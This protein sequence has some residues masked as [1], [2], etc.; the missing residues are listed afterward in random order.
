[1]N[2]ID[3]SKSEALRKD[4]AKDFTETVRTVIKNAYT[5]PLISDHWHVLREIINELNITQ[6]FKWIANSLTPLSDAIQL[7]GV[8]EL[9]TVERIMGQTYNGLIS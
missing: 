3:K 4:N 7:R 8:S 9:I 6:F 1:M 2:Y 5:L